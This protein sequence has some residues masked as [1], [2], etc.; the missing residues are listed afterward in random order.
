MKLRI[1]RIHDLTAA[2]RANIR[3]RNFTKC[4]KALSSS[5][6]CFPSSSTPIIV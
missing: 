4:A 6:L 1:S 2:R 3:L 5:V